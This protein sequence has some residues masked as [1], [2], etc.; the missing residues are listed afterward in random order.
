MNGSDYRDWMLRAF[1]ATNGMLLTEL[2]RQRSFMSEERLRNAFVDGLVLAMTG[3]ASR[4]KV[5]EPAPWSAAPCW[6]DP[7]HGKAKGR[8]IQHDVWIDA[9]AS[10][11]HGLACELKW[12]KQVK[13]A[14]VAQDLWKLAL[15]RGTNGEQASMRT[16]LL[17]GGE[18]DAFQPTLDALTS[19]GVRLTWS[20]RGR[21]AA[22]IPPTTASMNRFFQSKLGGT[23]FEKLTGWGTPPHRHARTPPP[24]RDQVRFAC[25]ASWEL[26]VGA[27]GW[28]LALWELDAYSCKG[29]INWSA[30][31]T[32]FKPA[33]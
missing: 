29:D 8:S 22:S 17:L 6:K 21:T 1:H 14:E 23:A 19:A 2:S 11:P 30:H 20:H 10:D 27:E 15:S 12:L 9:D 5:E 24:C 7:A 33:C 28:R 16:F 13:A 26:V 3:E 25:R 32:S 4:V 31:K 18:Q